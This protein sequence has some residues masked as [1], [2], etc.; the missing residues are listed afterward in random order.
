MDSEVAQIL[1]LNQRFIKI[2]KSKKIESLLHHPSF[3]MLLRMVSLAISLTSAG[4]DI[5]FFEVAHTD[6]VIVGLL[7]GQDEQNSRVENVMGR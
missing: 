3:I 2:S 5:L 7:S 6:L 1:Q 4:Q